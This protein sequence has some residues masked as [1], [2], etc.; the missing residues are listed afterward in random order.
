MFQYLHS[1]TRTARAL[2]LRQEQIPVYLLNTIMKLQGAA[3]I[4][5]PYS[6]WQWFIWFST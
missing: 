1:S 2:Y 6:M 3:Y 4:I 5:G